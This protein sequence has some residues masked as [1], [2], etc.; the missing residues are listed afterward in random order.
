MGSKKDGPVQCAAPL[1]VA[2]SKQ[3]KNGKTTM[4]GSGVVVGVKV[5][6]KGLTKLG[7]LQNFRVIPLKGVAACCCLFNITYPS[8]TP[9]LNFR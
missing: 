4:I 9:Y 3:M 7:V 6:I 5:M 8:L 1:R 2:V